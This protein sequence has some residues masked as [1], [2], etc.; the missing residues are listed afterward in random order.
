MLNRFPTKT[1]PAA[2]VVLACA[3]L[4]TLAHRTDAEQ[5]F[6]LARIIPHDV[7]LFEAT[8]KNPERQFLDEYWQQLFDELMQSGVHED[9]AELFGTSLGLDASEAQRID[10]LKAK[11][12]QLLVDVDWK[13]LQGEENVIAERFMPIEHVARHRPVIMTASVVWVARATREDTRKN[14]EALVAILQAVVDEANR[15][16]GSPDLELR[17]SEPMHARMATL[18]LLGALPQAPPLPLSVAM[19]DDLLMISLREDL[20]DDVLALM[21]ANGSASRPTNAL[22]DD[23]RFKAAFEQLPP[24]EDRMTYFDMQALMKP[25]RNSIN[26]MFDAVVHPSDVYLNSGKNAKASAVNMKALLAYQNKDYPKALELVTQA[27]EIDPSDALIMYNL[28]CFHALVGNRDEA[29][30]WLDQSVKAGFYAPH[31]ISTD[32]DLVTLRDDPTFQQAL[33]MATEMA[34][35]CG[36]EDVAINFANRG[37]VRRLRMQMQQSYEKKDY[38]QALE[39]LEQAYAL[40]PKDSQVL[41]ALACLHVLKGHVDK[42]LDFLKQAVDAG[43]YCP[44]Q[45]EKDADWDSLRDDLRYQQS[46]ARAAELAAEHANQNR[47]AKTILIK[48]LIDRNAD[49]AATFDYSASVESTDVHDVRSESISVLVPHAASHPIYSV[50]SRRQPVTDFAKYLPQETTSFSISGG[51]NLQELYKFVENTIHEGGPWGEELLARWEEM[52]KKVGVNFRQDVVELI[53]GDTINVTLGNGLGSVCMI[54]VSDEQQAHQ[55]MDQFMKTLP[56][57]ISEA[58]A[59]QP[60]LAVLATLAIRCTPLTHET[61]EGFQNINVAMSPKP[62][63]V[64]GTADGFL[65]FGS[66]AD[67][68]ALCLATSR[69]Q[70]PNIRQNSAMI[71]EAI[72]P[73]EQFVSVSL[74]DHRTTNK[75]VAAAMTT[76]SMVGGMM[77]ASVPKPELR[78]IV[79]KLTG[80]ITRLAP[81]VQH[82]NFRKSVASTTTFN[83]QLWRTRSVTHYQSPAERS[84]KNAAPDTSV[85][86]EQ[87]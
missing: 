68:V 69:N 66:S 19:R 58:I 28:A 65:V 47:A 41:Y 59:R 16:L 45:I 21:D 5:I 2:I 18:N 12:K 25:M 64:W 83:G 52:Q 61:L 36:A 40:A 74:T 79:A 76:A 48:H 49:A 70:H 71:R 33:A 39:F 8:R 29:L 13:H 54:K 56:Q 43:F 81:L 51:V 23:A 72:V 82:A 42:G 38:D 84:Q 24:A 34:R 6:T 77:A 63:G 73:D 1:L 67:A 50:F 22:A 78:P 30:D 87:Q 7:F 46:V 85:D 14:Y 53:Q 3:L 10:E 62:V 32:T 75:D 4:A 80:L 15:A 20:R 27:H 26:I 86:D 35:D 55:K 37:P 57:M 17:H 44:K 11:F 31:K 60:A 9:L